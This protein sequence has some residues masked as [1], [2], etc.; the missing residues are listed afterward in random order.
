VHYLLLQL[1]FWFN[2]RVREGKKA[3]ARWL[4]YQAR[5]DQETFHDLWG[6]HAGGTSGKGNSKSPRC[7]IF[8]QYLLS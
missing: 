6:L 3:Y 2:R 8:L 5:I 7:A 1:G 4:L